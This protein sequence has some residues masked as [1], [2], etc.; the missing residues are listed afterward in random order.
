MREERHEILEERVLLL[1]PTARD[2]AT[3]QNVLAT[4]GIAC[5]PCPNVEQLC[6]EAERGAGAAIITAEAVVGDKQERL[7]KFLHA[8]ARWSDFPIIV[9][10]APGAD[11]PKLVQALEAVGHTTLMKRPVQVSTLISTVLTAL[12]DRRRQYVVR[13]HLAEQQQA[14][15]ILESI[16]EGF[17]IF[18][19]EWRFTY[20]NAAFERMNR[21]RREDILGKNHWEVYPETVG[22][23][24]EAHYRRVVAEQVAVE[25]ENYCEPWGRWFVVKAYP[26][27][28]QGL[29]VQVRDVTERKRAEE[30]RRKAEEALLE[31]DRRKDDF[32]ALLAHELR[33]P[34][35]PIRNG[36]QVMRL[37]GSDAKAVAQ[38]RSMMDRQL[39]HMVRLIDDLLDVSRISRNKM[40][41]RRSRVLLVDVISSAVETARPAIDA[42]GHELIVSLPPEPIFLEAD[43]TRLAQVFSNLLTNSAKYTKHGGRIWLAAQRHDN[44]VTVSVRDNGIGIPRESLSNIFDMFSQVDRPNERAAGGLGIGLALVKGL[45]E[46]HGGTVEAASDGRGDGSTFT[47]RLPTLESPAAIPDAPADVEANRSLGR[48]I[49]AVD[50]NRDS[51]ASLAMM[52]Q[53]MGN[54]VATAH[55]G[56]EAIEAAERFRPDVIFMDV[57]MPKLNGL[58]ATRRIRQQPWGKPIAVIA[59]TGWGQDT[60]RQR[61]QEA[62]CDGHLVKPV[63][64]P[65][66]QRILLELE[67]K[68]SGG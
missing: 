50:D 17:V 32:I 56:L 54:E 49:L 5:L 51:A 64:F 25:F 19:A 67:D 3:T 66:L 65:D 58:D 45:V 59:L 7:A 36:L 40:E 6:R 22:T 46:M 44:Q 21:V 9:L 34:L 52:L 16:N 63:S 13:R 31:S 1:P 14:A 10:T 20:V 62:G 47:V 29:C 11:S 68:G 27:E 53:L 28:G 43:L 24:L 55:D 33:N 15:N 8:Q 39:D 23:A 61:S 26:A 2:A 41:L 30:E 37:A 18:D 48:R 60:D 35:A 57:G 4:A 12:R 38:A 42:E